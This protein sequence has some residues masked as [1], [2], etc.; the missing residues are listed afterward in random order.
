VQALLLHR[1]GVVMRSLL[2][3]ARS[4]VDVCG[5][6][7]QGVG[8]LLLLLRLLELL[9]LLKLLLLLE[10]LLLLV[11]LLLLLLV[12]RL[13]LHGLVEAVLHR[14]VGVAVLLRLLKLRLLLLLRL[15]ELLLLLKLLLLLGRREELGKSGVVLG[16][17]LARGEERRV[18][19]RG[20]ER[21]GRGITAS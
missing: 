20:H 15:L 14:S 4:L 13:L 2:G 16:N 18:S 1:Q 10:R 6:G 9:L 8:G 3:G 5:L 21:E 12:L 7:R 19:G 17:K 11:I